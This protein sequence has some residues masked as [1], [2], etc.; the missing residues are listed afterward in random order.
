MIVFGLGVTSGSSRVDISPLAQ[1]TFSDLGLRLDKEFRLDS[2]IS[3]VVK[4]S[5]FQLRQLAKLK[6]ILSKLHFRTV[7]CAF[8]TSR[9]DYCNSLDVGV[10]QSALSHLQLVQN[11][12]ARLLTG[13]WKREHITHVLFSLHCLPVLFRVHLKSFYFFLNL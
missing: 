3:A 8:I 4:S 13:T 1:S 5:F 6:N 10:S 12:A 7:I 9:L 2:Q 11:A